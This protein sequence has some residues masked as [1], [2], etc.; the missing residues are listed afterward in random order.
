MKISPEYI[1]KH[2]TSLV[3][4]HKKVV[5]F[6]QKEIDAIEEYCRIYNVKSQASLFRK[7]IMEHVLKALDENHPTL[8]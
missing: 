1:E 6:N 7:A 2:K 3:R 5:L 8:F 4:N